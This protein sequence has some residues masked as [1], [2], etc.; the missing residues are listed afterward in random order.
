VAVAANADGVEIKDQAAGSGTVSE[1]RFDRAPL[2][3]AEPLL[4]GAAAATALTRALDAGRVGLSAQLAGLAAGMLERTLAHVTRRVQFGRPI[5]SFQ[6]IQHRC[7]DL[8]T[9]M[10]LADATWRDALRVYESGDDTRIAISAAKARCAD[11]AQ[12][13]GRE[14]VQMHGAMGF[15]ED[16]DI[17]PY[18][19]AALYAYS[20]LGSPLLHRRRF[21]AAY[22]EEA[23]NG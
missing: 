6:V 18:L 4:D 22:C 19:R 12:R 13:I 20:W 14:A 11:T 23:G 1:V 17:G 16:A 2:M 3:C 15:T 21:L 10:R 7:V 8:Y 5:G 9:A